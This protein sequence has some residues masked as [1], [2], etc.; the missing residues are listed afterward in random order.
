MGVQIAPKESKFY[1]STRS[2]SRYIIVPYVY[3]KSKASS[4]TF[5]TWIRLTLTIRSSRRLMEPKSQNTELVAL[6]YDELN[7]Y[8]KL[9]V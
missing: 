1:L 8:T 5:D 4:H 6:Y 3:L 9:V 2:T 7:S